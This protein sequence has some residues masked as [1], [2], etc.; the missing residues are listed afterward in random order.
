MAVVTIIL[1]PVMTIST[2]MSAVMSA[3]APVMTAIAGV[4]AIMSTGMAITAAI[5]AT[6]ALGCVPRRFLVVLFHCPVTGLNGGGG[7]ARQ[8]QGQN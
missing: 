6:I 7:Q 1:G 8:D 2:I 4:V 5:M 3:V